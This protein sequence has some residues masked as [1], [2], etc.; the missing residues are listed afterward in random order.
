[1]YFIAVEVNIIYPKFEFLYKFYLKKNETI[2]I[3]IRNLEYVIIPHV[4]KFKS[5]IDI[6]CNTKLGRHRHPW[7]KIHKLL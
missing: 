2:T 7:S 1:M 5:Y 4:N 3:G 6:F